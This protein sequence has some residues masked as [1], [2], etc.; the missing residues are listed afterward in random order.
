MGD[1]P[2]SEDEAIELA[3]QEA[4]SLYARAQASNFTNLTTTP[5]VE[6]SA[7]C[8]YCNTLSVDERLH[9]DFGVNVCFSC[10]SN[11]K[12]EFRCISKSRAVKEYLLN[13]QQIARLPSA[14][15]INPRKIGWN[16]MKLYLLS[17]V[18]EVAIRTWG[19][20]D[21]LE[22][23]KVRRQEARDKRSRTK[24]ARKPRSLLSSAAPRGTTDSAPAIMATLME[25]EVKRQK[26]SA[27][28]AIASP[29]SSKKAKNDVLKPLPPDTTRR[30]EHV[31]SEPVSTGA[32]DEYAKTCNICGH[33]VVFESF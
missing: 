4:E 25:K 2:L 13:D 15:V 1:K 23:E 5:T 6:S 32:E 19:S 17:Q 18:K 26:Q 29:S 8:M 3:I 7:A 24:G 12:E 31:Y 14:T 28:I 11:R 9:R 27:S 22:E 20:L 16:D 21:E 10:K 33:R 30:H